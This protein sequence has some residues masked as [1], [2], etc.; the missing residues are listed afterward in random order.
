MIKTCSLDFMNREIYETDVMTADGR[1]LAASDEKV[2]PE[3]VLRLYFKEIYVKEEEQILE[4][5]PP[6]EIDIETDEAAVAEKLA[7]IN[8]ESTTESPLTP[9]GA[10]IVQSA[11]GV[12]SSPELKS[13]IIA[14]SGVDTSTESGSGA[15]IAG[16]DPSNASGKKSQDGTVVEIDE[17]LIFDEEEAN[18]VSE[19]SLKIGALLGFSPEKLEDLK[20]A[21]YYHNIGR[22]KFKQSDLSQKNFRKIQAQ[23]GYEI[24]INTM[25]QKSEIA[26]TAKF[27]INNYDTST[28]K[29]DGPI[30]YHHIVAIANYYN[31]LLKKNYSKQDALDKMVLLGGNKF[32]IFVLHKF[33][34]LMKDSNGQ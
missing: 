7:S 16:G 9:H 32:N 18:K 25:M 17:D 34:K 26:E 27:Y 6:Q 11:G 29:L 15:R 2:T 4:K 33:V 8:S 19:Y 10:S 24:L 28:F 31:S 5:Q 13:G 30:P 21:A 12:E 14:G 22:T 3:M 1:V 20:Q 23:A